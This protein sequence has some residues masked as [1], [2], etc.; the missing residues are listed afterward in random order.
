MEMS[1]VQVKLRVYK[2]QGP[3]VKRFQDLV[4]IKELHMYL[5]SIGA[6]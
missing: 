1:S 4:T 6:Q 3:K 2:T 5:N